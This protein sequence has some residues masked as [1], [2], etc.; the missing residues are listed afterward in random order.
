MCYVVFDQED[1]EPEEMDTT[2]MCG[3]NDSHDQSNQPNT[4]GSTLSTEVSFQPA[5]GLF[6][7]YYLYCQ[8]SNG[9]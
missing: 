4:F 9:C 6:S 3:S 5:T 7:S 8:V 2:R 1:D